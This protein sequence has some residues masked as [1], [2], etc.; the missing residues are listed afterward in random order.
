[1]LDLSNGFDD[2]YGIFWIG[3]RKESIFECICCN[4]Y[5]LLPLLFTICYYRHYRDIYLNFIVYFE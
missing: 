3:F 1:M 2:I 4:G 5:L